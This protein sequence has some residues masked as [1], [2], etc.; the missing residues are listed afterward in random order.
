MSKEQVAQIFKVVKEKLIQI[1]L[2][3]TAN[4]VRD[5]GVLLLINFRTNMNQSNVSQFEEAIAAL[6]KFRVN[7]IQR[8]VGEILSPSVENP[9]PSAKQTMNKTMNEK[10]STNIN[11]AA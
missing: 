9:S 5:A 11:M 1:V 6:P 2:K 10:P 4:N 3:D 8:R 7:E